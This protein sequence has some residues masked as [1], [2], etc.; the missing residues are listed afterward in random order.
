LN[1]SPERTELEL[2]HYQKR[3]AAELAAHKV[4]DDSGAQAERNRVRDIR[5]TK[6]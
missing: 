2:D 1:W 3:V 4:P 6:V 5:L